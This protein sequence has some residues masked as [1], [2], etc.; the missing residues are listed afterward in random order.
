MLLLRWRSGSPIERTEVNRFDSLPRHLAEN[1][2]DM[3]GGVEHGVG[4]LI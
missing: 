4:E 2:L 3:R 1:M